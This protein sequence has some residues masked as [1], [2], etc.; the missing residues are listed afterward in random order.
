M[1]GGG[2]GE[3]ATFKNTSLGGAEEFTVVEIWRGTT[4]QRRQMDMTK[5]PWWMDDEQRVEE[6][7]NVLMVQWGGGGGPN[8]NSSHFLL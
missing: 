5:D 7:K 4:L 1:K 8:L 3:L 2:R 6:N